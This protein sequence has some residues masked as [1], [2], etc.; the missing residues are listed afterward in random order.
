MT[1]PRLYGRLL[2][3]IPGIVMFLAV[4][5]RAPPVWSLF[6]FSVLAV[7]A[8]WEAVQLCCSKGINPFSRVMVSFLSGTAALFIAI[9][10]PLTFPVL[11]L[12][13]A[14]TALCVMITMG[15]EHSRR[16]IAGT[17]ALLSFYTIGFGLMGRLFL[18]AGAWI[19][20]AVLALCWIG[21]SAAYFTGVAFGKHKLMPRVSPK[22]SWEGFYG[23]LIGSTAGS[24]LVGHL[25][26]L[27]FVPLLVLGFAGGIAGVLGDLFESA[28]KR[29][30]GVKD[31][32][33]LLLGH[34]GI[35]DRFDSAAAVAPV[36]LVVLT[37]FGV[38][39]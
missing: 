18:Q 16:R 6:L 32:S 20:L 35:L 30:A 24:V 33:G 27:P 28:L 19:V 17:A 26:G 2:I 36:A 14:V 15:P 34:G 25:G 31:S 1:F 5:F 7:V 10:H 21:D 13:G 3:A 23:G 4:I 22:K 38:I 11:L 37:V 39:S 12:P 29:D 8:A 9:D